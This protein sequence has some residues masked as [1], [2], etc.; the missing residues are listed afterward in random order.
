MAVV[1]VASVVDVVEDEV[2]STALLLVVVPDAS[3]SELLHA[4]AAMATATRTPSRPRDGRMAV[5][6]VMSPQTFE[7]GDRF[8][9]AIDAHRNF[10]GRSLFVQFP[11]TSVC[12]HGAMGTDEIMW[13][14]TRADGEPSAQAVDDHRGPTMC[15]RHV[16]VGGLHRSGTS[17]VT[18]MLA[19]AEGATGLVGTGFM[20]DEGHYLHDVVPSVREFGGPGRF[21]F[22]DRS[23]LTAPISGLSEAH[24][25][26]TEAWNPFWGDP[27]AQIRVEKSPQ[28]LLQSRF[29]QAVFPDASFVMVVRHPAA[30][31]LAT[32]KW[33]GMGP[34][35]ARRFMPKRTLHSLIEHWVVAHERFD[36]DRTFLKDVTV[37]RFEDV[38][39]DPTI[40]SEQLFG[41]LGLAPRSNGARPP[42][43][44][45]P[46]YRH[47][48]RRWLGS[49]IGRRARDTWLAALAPSFAQWGYDIDD[50]F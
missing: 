44:L 40:V 28:N 29:L 4:L 2:V 15:E 13:P 6:V 23:H 36:A 24:R 27:S 38:V 49:P 5:E 25:Q 43:A 19:S 10:V 33:T 8:Q 46:T 47:Q 35:G 18:R 21:A 1:V 22:D 7:R 9:L 48:W 41:H 50:D 16:F 42:A 37:V 11:A 14:L 26:L 34:A 12:D 32:R 20:E 45:D 17:L 30:V 39:A 31:A 3:V